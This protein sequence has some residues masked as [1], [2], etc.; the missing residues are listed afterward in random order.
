MSTERK[1]VMWLRV[2][3][4]RLLDHWCSA[5]AASFSECPYLVGSAITREDY[6]DVDIRIPLPDE[7]VASLP[8]QLL[9][10][11]MMLSRWG[12]QAT[13]LPID[14][15]VQPLSEFKSYTGPAYPRGIARP[16]AKHARRR[17]SVGAGGTA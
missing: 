16:P 13:G 5:L 6:R 15:Q 3:E 1:R 14:C 8:M 4:V 7:V 12:Q 2:D 11:N 10:L 9:D 17:A